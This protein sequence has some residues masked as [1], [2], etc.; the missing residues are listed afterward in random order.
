MSTE[1]YLYDSKADGGEGE[2]L[3]VAYLTGPYCY[4][5][6]I[7]LVTKKPGGRN[8]ENPCNVPPASVNADKCP[9][10]LRY[11][12]SSPIIQ[13]SIGF[14]FE[15]PALKIA[16]Y[17]SDV[18][19]VDESGHQMTMQQFREQIID[20]AKFQFTPHGLCVDCNDK[21]AGQYCLCD[22]CEDFRVYEKNF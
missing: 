5:C 2:T 17:E 7:S 11:R 10:C 3:G 19:V 6:D 8:A 15:M 18:P 9:R 13:Q 16:R 4:N 21:P 20:M 12:G 22:E 1:Y 14:Y